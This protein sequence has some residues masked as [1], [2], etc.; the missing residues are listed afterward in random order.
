ME[1]LRLKRGQGTETPEAGERPVGKMETAA[2]LKNLLSQY[3]MRATSKYMLPE[4][5]YGKVELEPYFEMDYGYARLEFKIG[6]E[7]KYVL[8]NISAFLHSVQVNEKVHYGK[9]LDFYHHMEAFSENAK[10]LIRFMQQQDDD[11]KRQS[12]FHAYYAYTGGYERTMELDGVGID[13]FLEAVKGTPFHA[14]IGYDMNESYIYN[15]TKRKP[16]L[17]LKGGSAGAFLCMEDLPVI[18]GDKYYYFYEDGEIFLGEPLLKG[19]V[20]DFFQFLHRQVGGDCYIAAEELAMFCRDLLPMVRESFDVIPEGFDEALYV[21]PKPEFELYLDRQAMDVVGAKL[22]AVY[23]DNKY[24]VLAKVEPGEVRDLSEELRIKSLVEPYFNEYDHSKT[25]FVIA[26]DED[27]LYQL[28]A[29]GLQRLSHFMAIYTSD[30]FRNMKVVNAPSVSVGVSLKSDLLELKVHS[31]EMSSE[32]LAYLLSKYDRKKKYIRL[33]NGDFLDIK[34]DGISALAEVSED[35]Q[36]T[37]ASLKKGT[38]V[39]PKYRA[40]YLDAALKNNQLLSIEKNRE[41]KGMV[42]NMKT[43]E[44]SDYEVVDSLKNVMRNYQKNGFL[45]LK[46][47][48]ENGFGGI[49]ADDMGLG[50]TLQVLCYLEKMRKSDKGAKTLLVVPASLIGNWQKEAA[51]FVPDMTL[52]VIHGKT[53]AQLAQEFD[54]GSAFLTITTYGMVSR[55][56]AFQE[57]MWDCVILDEAQAIKNPGTK[58]TREIKKLQ[59]QMRIAMTGTP[60]EN[61]LTNLWSLFDFIDHGL[62]GTSKEFHEFTKGLEENPQEYAKLKSMITP[63]MLRRVKTD[64]TVI[65]DLPEKVEMTD[66]A[67]LTRKQTILYR[68]VVSDMEQ[69]VRQM[70][71]EHS[72]SQFAKKGIVLTA[73]MKLKQICN[74]PDQ[75]LGQDVY[76]PSESGKFQ[77]LK[78]ICETIYEKRER[79]LVFTQFKEIADDLAAYLE[80]VFHA[81]GY[82]LHGGTPVAKRTEIVDAFQ[83]EAYVPFIVLSVKAAGTGLNLTKANHVIHFDRW[84]NPAVEN[85]A[86]DRAFRIGQKKDVIVH[87]FVSQGTIEEKIDAMLESKKELAENVIGSGSEKWITELSNEELFSLLRL[88]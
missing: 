33:K 5:I 76:T 10:R 24:N 73:I 83:G 19:K 59:A 49:L 82:V 66:F 77:L 79:V 17:T 6:M 87:K 41:F 21:P 14:T 56:K 51:K 80:T 71:A 67:Q 50:K 4:T 78:E 26:K 1:I 13:R 28:V 44:D 39:I 52:Q 42:R 88:E 23:G 81:K 72:I 12:K 3:S 62:L 35:L 16:K 18:E 74:H 34:E 2:P 85:Q 15:G 86:T 68:K 8:K 9:K 40:M 20:S 69:K 32:E 55:I 57:T 43:I 84:W 22:V 25:F 65:A 75:Y 37:E 53:S 60:I 30:K 27:L 70:E 63:F 7:T 58:Q 48:R 47:L 38:V 64:K 45:W 31:D 29:G 36:L 11:K 46:T 61:D 54:A